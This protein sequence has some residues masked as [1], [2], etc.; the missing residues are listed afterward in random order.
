MEIFPGRDGDRHRYYPDSDRRRGGRM[1]AK[2]KERKLIVSVT[3]SSCR[4]DYYRGSGAGGQKRNKTS[5]CV[6]CTHEPSGSVG[7][8]EDG[9]SQIHNRRMA[10]RRMATTSQFKTWL[11]MECARRV[12]ALD[13]IAK[14]V[15]RMAQDVQTEIRVDGKWVSVTDA[16][17]LHS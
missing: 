11:R 7:K 4:W 15:D 16:Q 1:A 12:G 17:F 9:R 6:R 3:A 8:S 10:F 5:N 2:M 13:Q 14:R